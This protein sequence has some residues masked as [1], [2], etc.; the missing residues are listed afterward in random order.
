MRISLKIPEN[1]QSL[2]MEQLNNAGMPGATVIE[3]EP[4]IVIPQYAY[5]ESSGKGILVISDLK[6]NEDAIPEQYPLDNVYI[7]KK[8]LETFFASGKIEYE[9]I[10]GSNITTVLMAMAFQEEEDDI[11]LFKG[12]SYKFPDQF[13]MIDLYVVNAKVSSADAVAFQNIFGSLDIY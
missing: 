2:S 9:E 12:P 8:N 10:N 11:S 13:F 3:A 4:F 7:Y 6:F 5:A 1:F